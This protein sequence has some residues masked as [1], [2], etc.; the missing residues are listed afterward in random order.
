MERPDGFPDS[1]AGNVVGGTAIMPCLSSS[2]PTIG[3]VSFLWA[4]GTLERPPL[5]PYSGHLP[6]SCWT[7]RREHSHDGQICPAPLQTQVGSAG[8]F[9]R[10]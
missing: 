4:V 1:V 9:P 7:R 8:H 10:S 3:A 5:F 2:R 6:S